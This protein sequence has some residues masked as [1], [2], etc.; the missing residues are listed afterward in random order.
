[1]TPTTLKALAAELREWANCAHATAIS[2]ELGAIVDR[3]ESIA[4]ADEGV[5]VVGWPRIN[6]RMEYAAQDEYHILPPRLKRLWARLEAL[7]DKPSLAALSAQSTAADEMAVAL[8]AVVDAHEANMSELG[9]VMRAANIKQITLPPGLAAS[10]IQSQD[11]VES[12]RAALAA[13]EARGGKG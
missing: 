10:T 7:A 11:A 8:R 1:M 2:S 5:P 3:I 6:K 9:A 13:H 12:A 4:S